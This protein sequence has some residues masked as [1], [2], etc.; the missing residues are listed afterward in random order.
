MKT[1]QRWAAKEAEQTWPKKRRRVPPPPPEAQGEVEASGF[2]PQLSAGLSGFSHR[3]GC[4]W[5]AGSATGTAVCLKGSPVK[6]RAPPVAKRSP[7]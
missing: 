7:K 2:P 1:I 4:L 5:P 6:Q 3:V